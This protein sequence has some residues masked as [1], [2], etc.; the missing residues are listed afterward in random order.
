[1]TLGFTAHAVRRMRRWRFADADVIEA[2]RAGEVIERYPD[3]TPLPGRLVLGWSGSRPI[4]IVAADD[5][6]TGETIVITVY[7]PGP[8]RWDLSFRDRRRRPE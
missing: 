6:E 2:L 1:M 8:E 5:P 7:E 4:H 3:D